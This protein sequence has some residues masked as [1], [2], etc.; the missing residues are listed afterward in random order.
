[1]GG[2]FG[3]DGGGGGGAAPRLFLL[4]SDISFFPF[5]RFDVLNITF[6]E[7]VLR[8]YCFGRCAQLFDYCCFDEVGFDCYSCPTLIYRYGLYV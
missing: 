6:L 7:V 8:Q 1:L 2:G 3:G 5:F 4:A